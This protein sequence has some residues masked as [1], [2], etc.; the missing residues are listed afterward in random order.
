MHTL[1]YRAYPDKPAR[2]L[3]ILLP[4]LGDSDRDF[5][6]H[7]F[8]AALRQRKLSVDAITVNA[9]LGYYARKTFLARLEADVLVAARNVGYQE[10]WI[11]GISMGGMGSL[12]AAEHHASELAGVILMAPYLGDDN[13]ID[14]IGAAGGLARWRPRPK[15]AKDDYQRQLWGWLKAAT[16]RPESAP[17]IY[18]AAGDRDKLRSGH[19]LLANVLPPERV[20]HTKGT[21]DWKP[22]SVLWA[23]F[24]DHSDFAAHCGEL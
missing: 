9:T 12:V 11:G 17:K 15:L 20:F 23:D 14:E 21:H 8:I 24:L 19:R 5:A 18:L 22:W 1:S 7:G 4:G 3:L 6:D 13:L 16:E 2:C 10:I